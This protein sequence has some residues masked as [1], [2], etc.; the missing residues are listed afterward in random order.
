MDGPRD[1]HTES[2]KEKITSYRWKLKKKKKEG[3]Y[4]Y[5]HTADSLCYTGENNNIIKQLYFNKNF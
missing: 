3:V 2:Q 1:Y 4:I 5:I